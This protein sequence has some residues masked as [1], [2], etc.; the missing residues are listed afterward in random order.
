MPL[1][2]LLRHPPPSTVQILPSGQTFT[3]SSHPELH[4][5]LDPDCLVQGLNSWISPKIDRGRST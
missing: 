5:H 4:Y 1:M 2:G 3:H